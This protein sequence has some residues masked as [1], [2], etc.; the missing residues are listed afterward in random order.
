M[1]SLPCPF[2]NS[3]TNPNLKFDTMKK[4]NHSGFAFFFVALIN[5]TIQLLHIFRNCTAIVLQ[6]YIP[7]D[8][9]QSHNIPPR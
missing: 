3:S 7:W 1:F 2:Y 9:Y 6:D 4:A 5:Y 8:N